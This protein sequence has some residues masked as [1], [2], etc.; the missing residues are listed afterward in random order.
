M[1]GCHLPRKK[2]SSSHKSA[3][4]YRN[5]IS[6]VRQGQ[7]KYGFIKSFLEPIEHNVC[8]E[9]KTTANKGSEEDLFSYLNLSP[10]I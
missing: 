6:V 3:E 2:S 5:K 10:H 7:R 1:F 8:V 4:G 9:A